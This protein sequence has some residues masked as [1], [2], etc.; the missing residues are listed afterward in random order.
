MGH[1]G[2]FNKLLNLNRLLKKYKIDNVNLCEKNNK[3]ILQGVSD[4]RV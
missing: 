1:W 3:Y 2:L 4:L